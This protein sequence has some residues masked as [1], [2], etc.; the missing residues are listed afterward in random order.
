MIDWQNIIALGLVGLAAGYLA[1]KAWRRI[2]GLTERTCGSCSDCVAI[3]TDDFQSPRSTPLVRI[4]AQFSQ[5][6]RQ[7]DHPYDEAHG[8]FDDATG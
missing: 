7:A 6:D 2:G 8:D 3:S 5:A 1:R 4:T